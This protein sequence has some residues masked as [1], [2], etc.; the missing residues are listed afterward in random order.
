MTRRGLHGEL[1]AQLGQAIAVG[2]F[3]EGDVLAP[4]SIGERFGVSRTVVR[5][6]LRVLE[7]KGMV[8]AR[9]NTGTKVR[10]AGDWNLLDP[11]VIAWRA[12]GESD[13]EQTRQLLEL[14]TAFE[15]YAARL[16]ARHGTPATAAR[17]REAVEAMAAALVGRDIPAFT[18]ADLD[19]HG[20]LL[21]ASHNGLFDQLSATV[22]A[23]LRLREGVLIGADH[24]SKEAVEWHARVVAAIEAG[25]EAAAEATMRT[26]LDEVAHELD[27][28]LAAHSGPAA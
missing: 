20:A 21:G 3:A 10:P 22:A 14:R 18:R 12:S 23:A 16:A 7:A 1:V 5:E 15:P 17:L 11:D 25:D 28:H 6:A 2:T 27:E 26:M 9:P 8:T 13:D 4:E 24:V 19:F